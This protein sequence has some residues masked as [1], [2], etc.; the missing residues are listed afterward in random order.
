MLEF[1]KYQAL[2]KDFVLIDARCGQRLMSPEQARFLCHRRL[3]VGADGRLEVFSLDPG[4]AVLERGSVPMAGEGTFVDQEIQLDGERV[5][6]AAV[7][8]GTPHLVIFGEARPELACRL[9]PAG[10]MAPLT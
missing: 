7:V 4:P 2:G 8:A 1:W 5:R 9:G 6:A 10:R 3:G